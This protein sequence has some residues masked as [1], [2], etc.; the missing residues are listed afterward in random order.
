MNSQKKA[1]TFHF[2]ILNLGP[3][4]SL[5]FRVWDLG[6]VFLFLVITPGEPYI[7]IAIT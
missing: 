7:H 6:F 4:V 2:G 5:E 1:I 3:A